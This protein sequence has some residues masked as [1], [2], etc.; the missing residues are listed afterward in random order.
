M[1]LLEIVQQVCL[2]VGIASPAQ[3]ATST[4]PQILQLYALLNRFGR[5][6]SRTYTWNE[7]DK[8]FL[9]KTQVLT[10]TGNVT[11][12]SAVVT[13]IPSTAGITT[14]WGASF[15]GAVPFSQVVSVD[16]ATQVTLNQ[17]SASAGA[18]VAINFACINYALPSDWLRQIESTEWDRTNRWPLNGPKSPQEWQNFKSGIVYAGPR[19]RFRIQGGR[20]SINPPPSAASV[21]S[22]E[23]VSQ[24]WVT[25]ANGVT[26]K[27]K[28]TVDS[29][30][31][32]FDES[33]M[34][35]GL[36]LRWNKA[37]GFAYDER[38]YIDLLNMCKGQNKSAPTLSLG[39]GGGS[40]LLSTANLP[41]GNYPGG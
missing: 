19:L 9:V 24:D 14:D 5:D 2:E 13:N 11:A 28:F 26:T 29:D 32:V 7:L 34:V 16:S 23:Y 21:L 18:G 17:P 36:K 33:L 10:T 37:K 38:A 1:T 8:E 22:M 20:L 30:T 4:D 6:L 27:P 41:D 15:V 39:Q 12:N 25:A 40:I 3:V 35:E 31:P